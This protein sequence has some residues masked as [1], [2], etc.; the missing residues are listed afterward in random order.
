[1]LNETD[2]PA[3]AADPQPER[4]RDRACDQS[5]GAGDLLGFCHLANHR[6]MKQ[7]GGEEQFDLDPER[8]MLNVLIADK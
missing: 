6:E 2:G 8:G 3:R 1:V 7:Q 4:E 5:G